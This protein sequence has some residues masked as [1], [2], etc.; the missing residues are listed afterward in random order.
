VGENMICCS[1]GESGASIMSRSEPSATCGSEDCF[2]ADDILAMLRDSSTG[3]EAVLG[4]Q[5]ISQC[6]FVLTVVFSWF[7]LV[8]AKSSFS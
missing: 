4:L 2:A 8:K 7:R 1:G 6:R 5:D 3:Q